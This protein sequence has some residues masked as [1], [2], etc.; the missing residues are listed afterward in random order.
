ML[1][2]TTCANDVD[3]VR[4]RRGKGTSP[5]P[6]ERRTLISGDYLCLSGFAK[7]ELEIGNSLLVHSEPVCC[8]IHVF[9]GCHL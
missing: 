1:T 4:S 7:I 8:M 2:E 3:V 5:D 6:L 9:S